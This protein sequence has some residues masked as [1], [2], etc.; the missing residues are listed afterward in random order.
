[1]AVYD[2]AE[3]LLDL[4]VATAENQPTAKPVVAAPAT[5]RSVAR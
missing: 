3:V 5:V 4:A 1:L 2:P